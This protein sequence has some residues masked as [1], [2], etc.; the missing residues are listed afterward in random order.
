MDDLNPRP[1][2]ETSVE[3]RV[4][5]TPWWDFYYDDTTRPDGTTGHYSWARIHAGNGGAMVVPVT[6][7]G[8]YLLIKIYRYPVKRYLW[9]FPAG[10]VEDGESAV[11]AG[12]R[13][14][15]EETGITPEAVELLGSQTPISGFVGDTFYTVLAKIPEIE[16]D[17]VKPQ[18]EEGIV[19]AKLVTR[20]EIVEMAASQQIEDGVTLMC[21]ARYWAN[22]EANS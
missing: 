15:V 20:K 8:R 7:S 22:Q 21:L 6:P 9:E 13:E 3:H 12:R 17:D 5:E 14:L 2:P 18:I 10:M 1:T 11:E 4:F 16:I 19:D